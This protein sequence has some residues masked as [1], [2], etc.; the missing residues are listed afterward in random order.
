LSVNMILTS[1]FLHEMNN[2]SASKNEYYKMLS[3]RF[4]R[5]QRYDTNK[6]SIMIQHP[7][8]YVKWRV[9]IFHRDIEWCLRNMTA[10]SGNDT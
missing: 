7:N 5:R 3:P 2:F 8:V 1:L 6:E 4:E 10:N 9:G